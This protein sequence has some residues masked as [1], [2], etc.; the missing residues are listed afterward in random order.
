MS[1]LTCH[2][3][4]RDAETSST[5][6]ESKCLQC[7]TAKV[8]SESPHVDRNTSA[9]GRLI[10]SERKVACPVNPTKDCVSCHM[11][12]VQTSIPHTTFTDHFIRVHPEAKK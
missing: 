6:Y 3:P 7:H 1:C 9:V 8:G 11:P 10:E 5:Y 12:Q 4:H 2:D